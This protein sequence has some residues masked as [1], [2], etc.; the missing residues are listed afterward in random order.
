M[1]QKIAPVPL[2]IASG[3]NLQN[4]AG[5]MPYV[6]YFIVG[7]SVETH[8]MSGEIDAFALKGLLEATKRSPE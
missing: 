1:S 7:S 4:I 8:S 6:D 5:Y 2:A 3:V